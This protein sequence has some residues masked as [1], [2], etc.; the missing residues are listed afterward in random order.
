MVCD[1]QEKALQ[2]IITFWFHQNNS[3]S[4]LPFLSYALQNLRFLFIPILPS[5]TSLE[6]GSKEHYSMKVPLKD[7]SSECFSMKMSFSDLHTVAIKS[8][9][10]SSDVAECDGYYCV[11]TFRIQNITDDQELKWVTP[12]ELIHSPPASI[13]LG[14]PALPPKPSA[15]KPALPLK[16]SKPIR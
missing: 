7:E 6:D 14:K 12:A 5:I 2:S 3:A 10:S 9:H 15:S 11:D 16:P 4:I 13:E 1:Q 8:P